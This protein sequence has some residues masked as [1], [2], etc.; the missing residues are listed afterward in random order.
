MSDEDGN[1]KDNNPGLA[2]S[3]D[4]DADEQQYGS[5]VSPAEGQIN[6]DKT[7]LDSSETDI[8][9]ALPPDEGLGSGGNDNPDPTG[10]PGTSGQGVV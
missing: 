10:L 3:D 9:P 5:Q 1:V 8:D 7:G 4:P 2:A 6:S